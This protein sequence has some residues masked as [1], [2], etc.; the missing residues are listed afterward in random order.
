M[1][2][3]ELFGSAATSGA[4]RSRRCHIHSRL[5]CSTNLTD[6]IYTVVAASEAI[7]S[8]FAS[9]PSKQ[10][11][12]FDSDFI[13]PLYIYPGYITALVCQFMFR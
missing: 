11:N 1:S 6:P 3:A 9:G 12:I 7:V 8:G 13:K 5:A 10:G 4:A 2:A